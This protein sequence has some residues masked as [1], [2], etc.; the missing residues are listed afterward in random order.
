MPSIPY[1]IFGPST[2]EYAAK[3]GEWAAKTEKNKAKIKKSLFTAIKNT[4]FRI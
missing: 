2:G 1:S 4:I 3:I